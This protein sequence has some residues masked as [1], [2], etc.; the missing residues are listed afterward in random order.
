M[1]IS[2][3]LLR[4]IHSVD[5]NLGLHYT[6]ISADFVFALSNQNTDWFYDCTFMITLKQE[7]NIIAL[8]LTSK[9]Q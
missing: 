1:F 9:R 2:S 3:G 6:P 4:D 8:E 7:G 5:L